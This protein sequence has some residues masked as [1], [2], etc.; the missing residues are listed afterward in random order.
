MINRVDLNVLI[1][2]LR[3]QL[4]QVDRA[5]QAME[6]L[7]DS[8]NPG[9]DPRHGQPTLVQSQDSTKKA[10]KAKVMAADASGNSSGGGRH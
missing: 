10:V 8:M 7:E 2:M 5:I 4:A 1:L 3:L 9:L 6:R